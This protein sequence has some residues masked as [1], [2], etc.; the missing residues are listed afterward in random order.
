MSLVLNQRN[1]NSGCE[2]LTLFQW[3]WLLL[4]NFR[5]PSFSSCC[6]PLLWFFFQILRLGGIAYFLSKLMDPP[7]R[8]AVMLA[9]NH[10][11]E[12][13][14]CWSLLRAVVLWVPP[15]RGGCTALAV[16]P[17]PL[18]QSLGGASLHRGDT[19]HH[20]WCLGALQSASE[21]LWKCPQTDTRPL[22]SLGCWVNSP[23]CTLLPSCCRWVSEELHT[24]EARGSSTL[25]PCS[26]GCWGRRGSWH[27]C[28][29]EFLLWWYLHRWVVALGRNIWVGYWWVMSVH[30]WLSREILPI[31]HGFVLSFVPCAGR[32]LWTGRRSWL[33]W[34][35]TWPGCP[36][37]PTLGRWS[38]LGPC[39]AAWTPCWPLQPASA[40]RTLLSSLW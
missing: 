34:V 31:S 18:V 14:K 20:P 19:A 33:P 32:M 3:V 24:N 27:V 35:C 30:Q 11:M 23:L 1:S 2:L 21:G 38:C 8:D 7:S 29:A 12:L 25:C 28:S 9:I 22:S 40:S 26:P 37:S 39:S 4:A 36:W 17:L 13:V 6:R 16:Q 5:Q 10:L 15:G